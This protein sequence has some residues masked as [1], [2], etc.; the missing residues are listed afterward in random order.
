MRG[1]RRKGPSISAFS[2]PGLSTRRLLRRTRDPGHVGGF[3]TAT[4]FPRG[5]RAGLARLFKIRFASPAGLC[6]AHR[7]S[8]GRAQHIPVLQC[9]RHQ[10]L[11]VGTVLRRRIMAFESAAGATRQFFQRRIEI[12]VVSAAEF[13]GAPRQG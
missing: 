9:G 13:G 6:P 7:R 12:A 4:E 1:L 5:V 11:A 10:P 8:Q 2:R 3:S